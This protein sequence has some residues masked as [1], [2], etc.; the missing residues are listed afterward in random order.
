MHMLRNCDVL[1]VLRTT[2]FKSNFLIEEIAI[3][4]IVKV[5]FS[6]IV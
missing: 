3:T 4:R 6:L 2:M 1:W 5:D